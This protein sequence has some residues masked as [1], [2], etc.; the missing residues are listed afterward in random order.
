MNT[1]DQQPSTLKPQF[2]QNTDKLR[3]EFERAFEDLV[4][5]RQQLECGLIDF[6]QFESQ[7]VELHRGLSCQSH[8]FGLSALEVE[9]PPTLLEQGER[10]EPHQQL[11]KT[12]SCLDGPVRVK[13]WCYKSTS[14]S[15]TLIPVEAR[16]G[17]IEGQYT[18]MA[19]RVLL[20]SSA[21]QDYRQVQRLCE[22]THLLGRSKSSAQRDVNAVTDVL[23]ELDESLEMARR[24]TLEHHPQAKSLTVSVDRTGLP[25]E[26]ARPRPVGKPKQGAPKKPCQVVHRQVYCA[27][28][29]LVDAQGQVLSTQRFGALPGQDTELVQRVSACVERWLELHEK[30]DLVTLCDGAAEMK[31]LAREILGG[32]EPKAELVD[33][34]HAMEYVHQAVKAAGKPALWGEVLT[35]RLLKNKRGASEL[36]TRMRTWRMEKASEVLDQC[37]TFF[38]NQHERMQYAAAREKGW[39]IGSGN[40][41]ATCKTV[42]AVRFKRSGARWKSKGA[43]PLLKVRALMASDGPV[44]EHA[45]KAFADTYVRSLA[46]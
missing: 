39:L 11:S 2:T 17:L 18:A 32:R 46:S 38:E 34:W 25:F 31:R 9:L 12:Y 42:V 41:E 29:C 24:D 6:A 1:L 5:L 35:K 43:Q 10:F 22:A 16:A 44:W 26:E 36:L 15:R 8:A 20:M 27:C 45:F 4:A 3:L 14:S 7:A 30:L 33:A 21:D 37:I 13:V 28:V 19:M 40:V 23:H